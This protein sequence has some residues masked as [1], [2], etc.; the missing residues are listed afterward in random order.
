MGVGGRAEGKIE[1][2]D[3]P[4]DGQTD[5]QCTGGGRALVMWSWAKLHEWGGMKRGGGGGRPRQ[6]LLPALL[7]SLP[8]PRRGRLLH[9]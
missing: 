2:G 9:L 1:G 6:S 3:R 4:A 8:P 7:P 5:E